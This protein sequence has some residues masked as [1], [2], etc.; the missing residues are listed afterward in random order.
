MLVGEE[1]L[2]SVPSGLFGSPWYDSGDQRRLDPELAYDT[3]SEGD[4]RVLEDCLGDGILGG[5]KRDTA[6]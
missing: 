1:T 2:A 4:V 3:L 5:S 6:K